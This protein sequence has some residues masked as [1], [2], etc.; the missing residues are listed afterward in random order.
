MRLEIN[1]DC[2]SAADVLARARR[3]REL[4]HQSVAVA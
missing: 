4:R 2:E 1:D 3:V